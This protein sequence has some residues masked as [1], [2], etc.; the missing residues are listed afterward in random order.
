MNSIGQRARDAARILPSRFPDWQTPRAFIQLGAGFAP[1]GLFDDELGSAPLDEVGLA[2]PRP[3]V[4]GAPLR[5]LLGRVGSTQL[6]VSHG[7][8]YAFEGGGLA[9]TL[10][11][12][13]AAALAGIPDIVLVEAGCTLRQ[14]LRCG[15]WM[16]ATDYISTAGACPVE[17][18][19]D[20]VPDPFRDMTD[21]LS[22][23]LN[24]E[25][26]NAASHAGITPR[27]GVHQAAAGPQFDTP[28]EA[29]A[30]RRGGADMLGHGI[31]AE[32]VLASLLG[33]RVSA[34]ILAAETA[35]GYHGRRPQRANVI[36]AARFCSPALM[37]ALRLALATPDITASGAPA[38]PPA[39]PPDSA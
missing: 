27:L 15:P 37:R 11:P 28:A 3:S 13:A 18:F 31:A 14:D 33:C 16:A 24:A 20:I 9:E 6:L 5:L 22:Q 19:V 32:T 12:V 8:R 21:A 25:I 36:E 17:G 34:L 38:T 4:T 26:I 7:H 30:A 35:A 1:E 2:S 23:S 29:E 10:L 39:P